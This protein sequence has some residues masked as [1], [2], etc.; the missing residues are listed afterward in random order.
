MRDDKNKRRAAQLTPKERAELE[1]MLAKAKP[2]DEDDPIVN[3][4][5]GERDHDRMMA[6]IARKILDGR[7]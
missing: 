6:T 7:L 2:Y 5:D 3:Q 1:A 4:F